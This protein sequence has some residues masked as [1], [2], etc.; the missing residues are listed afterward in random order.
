M[1]SKSIVKIPLKYCLS[2][3]KQDK[4]PKGW[5][6]DVAKV[7]EEE[8]TNLSLYTMLC[9]LLTCAMCSKAVKHHVDPYC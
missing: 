4:L 3:Q 9:C 6:Y 1:P 7:K 2:T 5:V 8:H